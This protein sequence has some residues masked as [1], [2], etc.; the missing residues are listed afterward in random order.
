MLRPNN[1]WKWY[2]DQNMNE[3][4]LD[5][6]QDMTFQVA[7]AKKNLIPDAFIETAF[8][9]DDASLYITFCEAITALSLSEPRK[10][11]L[12]L[13]AVAA[14]RF[15][16]PLLPKSWF[17]DTQQ[18][19]YSPPVGTIVELKNEHNS[20]LFIVIEN[21]GNASLCMLINEEPFNLTENKNLEFC[22]AIKVMNDRLSAGFI[23]LDKKTTD[24]FALVG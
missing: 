19:Y 7:I 17:F 9:V 6:G 10:A 22:E 24:K 18:F 16:K 8:S 12:I 3:L 23:K 15:H 1:K 2:Y 11:E 5:L 14:H 13:N 4:M 21:S 20:G